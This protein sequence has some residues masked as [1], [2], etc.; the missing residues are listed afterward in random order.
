VT[1]QGSVDHRPERFVTQLDSAV[2]DEKED[3]Q[4]EAI[5]RSSVAV[6]SSG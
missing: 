1:K 4:G 3:A 5:R 6:S 2:N